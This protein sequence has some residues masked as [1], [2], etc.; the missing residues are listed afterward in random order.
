MRNIFP[1]TSIE[2]SGIMV[3]DISDILNPYFLSSF[4][5]GRIFD[6]SIIIGNNL[7]A[8]TNEYDDQKI[9]KRNGR[10][11]LISLSDLSF[12]SFI[13]SFKPSVGGG[14]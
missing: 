13:T 7:Y 8:L 10:I 3:Y 2:K 9:E 6:D 1:I 12:P 14:K 4:Q 11:D 5:N